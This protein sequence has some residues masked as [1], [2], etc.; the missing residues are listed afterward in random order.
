MK[1]IL[2]IGDAKK[3]PNII[4]NITYVENEQQAYEVLKNQGYVYAIIEDVDI[5][6]KSNYLLLENVI[7]DPILQSIP[8]VAVSDKFDNDEIT[9]CLEMGFCDVLY[10]PFSNILIQKRLYN[11]IKS[12]GSITFDEIENILKELPSNIY[13]KDSQGRYIFAT[14]YWRHI[15]HSDP[16]FTIRGKTDMDIRKD[17][18]N[19]ERAMES[20]NRILKTGKSEQY[21]I[22]ENCDGVRE[23]LELI[24]CPVH[25]EIGNVTGIV[26]LINNVTEKEL[27][28]LELEKQ[29]RIDN[30]TGIYNKRS[31]HDNIIKAIKD[32]KYSGALLMIDLDDF[33]QINDEFGH[34]VGDNVLRVVG[35][36]LNHNFGSIDIAGRI[37]GDEFMVYIRNITSQNH[38]LDISN[39]LI[40]QVHGSFCGS[41]LN[42]VS[43]SIGIALYPK[44]GNTFDELYRQADNA[45]YQVKK[46]NKGNVALA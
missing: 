23:F 14:H 35:S 21:V 20:D 11:D 41:L 38:A 42:K 8:V 16:H 1:E 19:A 4:N 18:V 9:K 34:D 26:G 22:E 40:E 10:P 43:I 31:T 13:L 17:K 3:F 7:K 46:S 24:K 32:C 27:L 33:K 39:K 28:K 29:S 12:S 36:I 15:E 45:L 25:D 44:D 30:L 6:Y 2:Y 5:A 37:G